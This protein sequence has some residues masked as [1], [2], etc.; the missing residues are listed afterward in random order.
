VLDL[1]SRM[2]GRNI[3]YIDKSSRHPQRPW[4]I[5]TP[6]ALCRSERRGIDAKVVFWDQRAKWGR[7]ADEI[8]DRVQF[9]CWWYMSALDYPVWDVCALVG[10]GLPRIY[11]LERLDSVQESRMLARVEEWVERYLVGNDRPP[12]GGS[13]EATDWLKQAYPAHNRADI[14][15]ATAEEVALLDEYVDLRVAEKEVT[16]R[17]DALENALKD[18]IGNSEGLRWDEGTFTWRKTKDGETTRW[19]DMAQRLLNLY[20]KEEDR[21]TTVSI[22]TDP[23]PGQ[24]R[25]RLNHPAVSGAAEKEAA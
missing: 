15:E 17:R 16:R 24:R 14:R 22:Y 12:I 19:K 6:D 5:F 25:I 7:E 9:Q 2:T 1:Y 18:A 8:P 23:K 20:V 3:D 21:E 13:R 10:E 11:T 4:Q